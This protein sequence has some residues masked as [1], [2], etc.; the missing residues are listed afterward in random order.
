MI[1]VDASAALE[2]LIQTLTE[3]PIFPGHRP[4]RVSPS[5]A[6]IYRENEV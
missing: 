4:C 5:R 3:L 2:V 1:V 6:E